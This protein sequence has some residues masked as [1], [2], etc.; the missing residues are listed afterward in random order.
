MAVTI[1]QLE[2][3]NEK[4]HV[5]MTHIE[6]YHILNDFFGIAAIQIENITRTFRERQNKMNILE[7]NFNIIDGENHERLS[8]VIISLKKPIEKR[9]E[10]DIEFIKP[11]LQEI[12]FFKKREKLTSLEFE[13]V[14]KNIKYE[15]KEPGDVIYSKLDRADKFYII[16]KGKAMVQIPC[17][18][19]HDLDK[20]I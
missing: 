11:L 9:V 7:K 15:I 8:D 18:D 1:K 16:L 5:E 2:I 12:D 17:P 20:A 14:A 4:N 19:D 6:K 10:R 13:E 3:T